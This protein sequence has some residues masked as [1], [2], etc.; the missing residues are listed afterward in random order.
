M[1]KANSWPIRSRTSSYIV[2]NV[3]YMKEDD[4]PF[5]TVEPNEAEVLVHTALPEGGDPPP[6]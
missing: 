2:A 6:L 1:K 3:D 5:G 4:A